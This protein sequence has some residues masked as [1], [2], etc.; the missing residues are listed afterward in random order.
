MTDGLL[1]GEPD[2]VSRAALG[3]AEHPPI[4]ERDRSIIAATLGAEMPA[5]AEF[6]QLVHSLSVSIGEAATQSDLV[7]AEREYQQML[8]ACLGC[9]SVYKTRV[10]QAL[11]ANETA[12]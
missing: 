3:I 12:P 9:H 2:R 10:A 11:G 5:F 1:L 7:R 8:N 6:D 4:S